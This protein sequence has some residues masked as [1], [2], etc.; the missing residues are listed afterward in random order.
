MKETVGETNTRVNYQASELA[1][2]REMCFLNKTQRKKMTI[3]TKYQ[4]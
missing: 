4:P 3:F 2:F 1:T